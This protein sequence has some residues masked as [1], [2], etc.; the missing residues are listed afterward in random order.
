MLHD[1]DTIS[2]LAVIVLVMRHES[3]ISAYVFLIPN[4]LNQALDSNH[5][6]L[7]HLV[8]HNG[9]HE[10]SSIFSFAHFVASRFSRNTVS[11]LAMSRRSF[12]SFAVSSSCPVV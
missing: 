5:N 9:S 11:I 4:I 7:V 3:G 10:S 8:A 1:S 12:K 6:G 2:G